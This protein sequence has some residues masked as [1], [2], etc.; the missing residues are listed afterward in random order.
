MK[1][2]A[3][4]KLFCAVYGQGNITVLN[5]NGSVSKRIKTLGRCPTNLVFGLPGSKSFFVTEVGNG[6]LE[7]HSITEDGMMLYLGK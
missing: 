2:S 6:C 7:R 1:F 5:R 3:S 4:G